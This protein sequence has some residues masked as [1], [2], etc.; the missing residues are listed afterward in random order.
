MLCYPALGMTDKH[1]VGTQISKC[2]QIMNA[3]LL[4]MSTHKLVTSLCH[5]KFS[6]KI[7]RKS[8]KYGYLLKTF[9]PAAVLV[10]EICFWD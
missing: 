5:M 10:V 6:I 3:L 4:N 2:E 9:H 7:S 8:I 1:E